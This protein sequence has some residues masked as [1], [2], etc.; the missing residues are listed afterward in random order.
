MGTHVNEMRVPDGEVA[1]GGV[2]SEKVAEGDDGE[3]GLWW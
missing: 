3:D 1:G 2:A